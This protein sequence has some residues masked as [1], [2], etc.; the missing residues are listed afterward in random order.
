[1]DGNYNAKNVYFDS[2]LVLTANVGVQTIPSSGSKTLVTTGKN[3]KQVLDMLFAARKLPTRT[4][5]AVS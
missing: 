3:V 5:P 2:D 4:L 1:M